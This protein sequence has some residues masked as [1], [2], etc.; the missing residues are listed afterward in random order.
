[1]SKYFKLSKVSEL[2]DLAEKHKSGEEVRI[3]TSDLSLQNERY[4]LQFDFV[5]DKK[6]RPKMEISTGIFNLESTSQGLD[7]APMEINAPT[8][9]ETSNAHVMIDKE[10]NNFFERLDIYENLG[11]LKKRG[12]LLYGAPGAGKSAS[13][14]KSLA[15]LSENKDATIIIWNSSSIRSSHVLDLFSTGVK[16]N[17]KVKKLIIVIEDIGMGVEGY[18]GSKEVDKSLLNLLDGANSVIKVPTFFVATTNYAHNLPEPLVRPGRFDA[19]VEVGLP[20]P[21]ERVN[22][23]KFFSKEELSEEDEKIIRSKDLEEFSIAHVKELVIRSKIED[24]S[25]SQVVK[26]LKALRKKFKKGFEG[27]SGKGGMLL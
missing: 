27:E 7:L 4:F 12:V 9:L 21:E 26:E 8:L 1:M 13:I 15:K 24:K 20:S 19:W 11:V 17:E 25:Y 2:N 5:D 14:S 22:L 10:F 23:V 16:Y 3:D 18:G 6:E